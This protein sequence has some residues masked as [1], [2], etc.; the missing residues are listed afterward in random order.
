MRKRKE[1]KN[2]RKLYFLLSLLLLAIISYSQ[3]KC[4]IK[5]GIYKGLNISNVTIKMNGLSVS[6]SYLLG[7]NTGLS[8]QIPIGANIYL[9]PELGISQLGEKFNIAHSSIGQLFPNS[10]DSSSYTFKSVLNYLVVPVLIKYKAPNSGLRIY[11][12][13]QY[14]CMLSAK[15]IYKNNSQSASNNSKADYNSSDFSA[16]IGA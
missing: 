13:P 10:A 2:M 9:Q 7:S 6:P 3:Q 8:A 11:A 14:G 12:G 4:K 1:I 16:I 15:D 5:L